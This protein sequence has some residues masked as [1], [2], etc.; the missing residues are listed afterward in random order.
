MKKI[1]LLVLVCTTFAGCSKDFLK[2]YDTRIKGTWQLV[3][4]D[5]IGI[6]G[7]T[8]NLTFTSG[9]F[10]FS[11]GGSLRYV[12]PSG[13]IYNGS[14]DIRKEWRRG[15]CHTDDDGDRNCDDKRVKTLQVTVINFSGQDVKSEHFDEMVFTGTDRFKAYIYS[16]LHTY[17][18]R[19]RR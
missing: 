14:W 10:T 6:G 18:F 4:V 12:D 17:V 11:D 2:Q 19:F 5:R 1:Y 15:D 8:S 7:S 16:G 13:E 9:Q 3:D